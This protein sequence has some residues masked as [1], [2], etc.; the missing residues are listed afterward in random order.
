M[1]ATYSGSKG[2]HLMQEFLPN[3]FPAGAINPCPNCPTGFQYLVSN[4]NATRHS[5]QVQLRRRLRNGLT[6]NIQYT[7]SKAIDDA[8]FSTTNPLI[9]QNWLDLSA[10]RSLSNFDQRHQVVAQ[11]QYTTGM[12]S[13]PGALLSGWRG[14]LF[15]VWT[16]TAQITAGSGS[17]LTPIYLAAVKGTGVTGSIRPDYTGAPIYTSGGGVFLN[18]AAYVAPNGHWGNAGRNSIIGPSQFAMTASLART[19]RV[20]DRVNADLRLDATNILN[21]VTYQNWN[22]IITSAQFGA[23]SSTNP[24]R[25]IQTTLRLRF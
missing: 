8:G 18:H 7:L 9:A 24:M 21:H 12:G 13:A 1:T 25:K 22:A 3:T 2:T 4:G 6:A 10:D 15:K 20:N 16:A 19:L 17:P 11:A 5:G 23:P 14:A